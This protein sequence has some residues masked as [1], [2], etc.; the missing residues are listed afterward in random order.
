MLSHF[1][2]LCFP[3]H[4]TQS[5]ITDDAGADLTV[6]DRIYDGTPLG[7]AIY[8]QTEEPDEIKKKKYKEIE[9]YLHDKLNH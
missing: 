7:W 5:E 4:L 6:K 1:T 9:N 3:A 8:L 2:R